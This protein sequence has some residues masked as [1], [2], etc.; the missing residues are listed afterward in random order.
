MKKIPQKHG[1]AINR[2]EKGE[3]GNPNGRPPIKPFL[4]IFTGNFSEEDIKQAIEAS[5]VRAKKGDTRAFEVLLNRI[6][7][8]AKQIVE[9]TTINTE[10][11]IINV[12]MGNSPPI[13]DKEE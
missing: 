3:V 13:T 11:P 6:Y 9:Q 12:I 2:F 8:Q 4:D 10:P 5:L 7:G 1:G